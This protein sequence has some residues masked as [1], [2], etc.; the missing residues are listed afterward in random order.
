MTQHRLNLPAVSTVNG[1]LA[2]GVDDNTPMKNQSPFSSIFR[3][4]LLALLPLAS[5]A[6]ALVLPA[7]SIT[8]GRYAVACSNVE[9]DFTRLR[10]GEAPADYWEGNPA[11][12]GSRYVTDLLVSPANALT[13]KV[14]VPTRA[15]LDVFENQG[16]KQLQYAAVACYPTTAANSRANYVLPDGSVIPK[17]QR[18]S[19]APLIASNTEAS[20]GKWPLIVMSHGL[21]GSPLGDEYARVIVRLAAEGYVVFAPFHADARYSKVKLNNIS[22]YFYVLSQYPEIAEMQAIRP[23][24]LKQGLDYILSKPEYANT[25]D[26]D[27]IAGFGASLGGMAM[28]LAQGAT[29]T[30]SLGGAERTIVRD[31]RYK[32]IVGYVPFSGYS[33]QPA[34]GDSNQGVKRVRVPYLGIG[35]TAD[36]VAPISRTSQMIEALGGSKYFVTIQD[37]PHGLRVQ[38]APEL[39]GWTFAFLKAHLGRSQAERVGFNE[40]TNFAG[41]ADDRVQLR[42]TLPWGS[43]DEMEVVEYYIKSVGKFFITGLPAEVKA[44]DSLPSEFERTG[45]RFATHRLDAPVGSNMCRFWA[46]DGAR[47]NTHFYSVIPSD[48]A[49]LKAQSWARDE[50]SVMR[51]Q[52]LLQTVTLPVPAPPPQCPEHTVKVFRYFN[53]NLINHRYVP[54]PILSRMVMTADWMP[55]GAVFCAGAYD[56]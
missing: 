27:Q 37:M 1:W 40:L 5:V 45:L 29:M 32:A 54:E 8:S 46:N 43:R 22:D 33:F 12:A 36:I 17:M 31:D 6:N 56:R 2:A 50:G 53:Q 28:M 49:L 16:G 23:L 4:A 51:A 41:N 35:G 44:L 11:S 13:Y 10:S 39:F 48:C 15:Q 21:A 14:A 19:E 26:A 7:P 3:A 52:P 25:I 30:T 38:D 18:G 34:F 42:T 9:Q 20:D 47:I 55:D 24:G